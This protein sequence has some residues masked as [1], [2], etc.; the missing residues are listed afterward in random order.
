MSL[1][2]RLINTILVGILLFPIIFIACSILFIGLTGIYGFLNWTNPIE[3]F[4]LY[5]YLKY[6]IATSAL[7]SLYWAFSYSDECD[8]EGYVNRLVK[9][10][11]VYRDSPCFKNDSIINK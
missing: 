2:K 10:E 1:L 6:T 9:A 8:S 5:V 11:K 3:V 7:I 4:S